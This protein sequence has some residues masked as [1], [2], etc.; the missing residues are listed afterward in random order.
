MSVTS[1]YAATIALTGLFWSIILVK[2]G[3]PPILDLHSLTL[4]TP[5]L[6]IAW[7]TYSLCGGALIAA[8]LLMLNNEPKTR[9]TSQQ[10]IKF[11]IP[12]AF[13]IPLAIRIF[14]LEKIPLT[15][16]EAVYEF[17][18]KLMADFKLSIPSYA[19][20]RAFDHIF[21]INDGRMF[22]QYFIGWSALLAIAISIGF[23]DMLAPMLS[24]LTL[25]PLLLILRRHLSDSWVTAGLLIYCFSFLVSVMASTLLSHTAC[26]FFILWFIFFSLRT[27]DNTENGAKF[28]VAAAT[29]AS[30][31]F[32]IRPSTT[33]LACIPFIM[34]MMSRMLN[35]RQEAIKTKLVFF[36]ITAAIFSIAFLATNKLIYGSYIETGYHQFF[37]FDKSHGFIFFNPESYQ[38]DNRIRESLANPLETL[39]VFWSGVQRLSFDGM[40]WPIPSLLILCTTA[41]IFTDGRAYAVAALLLLAVHTLIKDLGIDSFGPT[42]LFEALPLMLVSALIGANKII[43]ILISSKASKHLPNILRTKSTP[44]LLA[45]AAIVFSIFT[46]IPLRAYNLSIIKNN[47]SAPY[48]AAQ[49]LP[50]KNI[51][52]TDYPFIDQSN[53]WPLK[54]YVYYPPINS[55]DLKDKTLW[56]NRRGVIEDNAIL[57]QFPD[58]RAFHLEWKKNNMVALTE[59]DRADMKPGK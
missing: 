27:A 41:A 14:F 40:N 9:I 4:I 17:T 48:S 2:L 28:A 53:I 24:A 30:I 31:A 18:A 12:T 26:N 21:L 16:D 13:I 51:I 43:S 19:S 54:H 33:L 35:P 56:V 45:T 20:P 8:M 58:R 49:A 36:T 59:L 38:V 7:I 44:T 52:F 10:L 32:F 22:G 1:I 11:L 50:G 3:S 23:Q 29:C 6:G 42:H 15:D 37:I 5:H 39:R 57:N 25:I 46:I 47:I 55:P 34:S